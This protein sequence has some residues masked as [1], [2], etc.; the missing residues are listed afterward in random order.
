LARLQELQG[1]IDVLTFQEILDMVD[2]KDEREFSR[3]IVFAF[4]EQAEQTFA[5]MD[6]A[7]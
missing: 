6:K 7:L 2:D 3:S 1:R 5:K 4:F